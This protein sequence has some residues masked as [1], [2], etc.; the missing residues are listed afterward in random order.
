MKRYPSSNRMLFFKQSY[1]DSLFIYKK[2]KRTSYLSIAELLNKFPWKSF[3]QEFQKFKR[4]SL[5][6]RMYIYIYIDREIVKPSL[7]TDEVD[8]C[9]MRIDQSPSGYRAFCWSRRYDK[10][11]PALS[12]P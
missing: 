11:E 12:S 1:R 9:E 4:L 6:K 8:P 5:R 3:F 10:N 7:E 2:I